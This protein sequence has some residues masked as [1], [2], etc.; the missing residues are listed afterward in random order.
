MYINI[1]DEEKT[2]TEGRYITL[3]RKEVEEFIL[4]LREE[5]DESSIN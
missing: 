3:E 5:L 4:L 2:E 1:Y